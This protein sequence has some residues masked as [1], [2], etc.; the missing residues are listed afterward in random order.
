M[1]RQHKIWVEAAGGSAKPFG[2]GKDDIR[3]SINVGSSSSNS[4]LLSEI[5]IEWFE[6]D[7]ELY[8]KLIIDGQTYRTEKFNRKTKEFRGIDGYV[9]DGHVEA[10]EKREEEQAGDVL[11]MT[12]MVAAMGEI[13][14]STQ[15]EKNDWKARMIKAGLGGY[16]FEMP[17][18]WDTLSEDEKERRLNGVI[19]IS[20]GK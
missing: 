5:K 14:G 20:K 19:E 7:G 3:M 10:Q 17:E 8:F 18:D 15:E 1:S 4:R 13:F 11:K 9:I 6:S 2:C 16:G 12:G